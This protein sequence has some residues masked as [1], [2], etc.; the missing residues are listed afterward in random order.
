[1]IINNEP[2]SETNT[3][4]GGAKRKNGHKLNCICHICENIK[5]K[6]NRGGYEEDIKKN[7]LKRMGGSKKKNGHKPDCNCPICKNMKMYKE[8]KGGI[9]KNNGDEDS[10]DSSTSSSSSSSSEEKFYSGGKKNIK[11]GNG[12]KMSCGC[13]ICKNNRNKKGGNESD[14]KNQ[15]SQEEEGMIKA[16]K[17]MLDVTE[18]EIPADA[19]EYDELELV[20]RGEATRTNGGSIRKKSLTKKKKIHKLISRRKTRRYLKKKISNRRK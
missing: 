19:E 10:D 11:R 20:E 6:A 9:I 7:Q 13:P 15:K 3:H 8:Q 17:N 12:H 14:I 5:N 16:D 1:M 2:K 18:N 4:I